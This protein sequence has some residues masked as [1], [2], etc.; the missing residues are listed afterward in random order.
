MEELVNV[1]RHVF[2]VIKDLGQIL[3]TKLTTKTNSTQRWEALEHKLKNTSCKKMKM[4][5]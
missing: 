3:K 4:T 5:K 1:K 2:I